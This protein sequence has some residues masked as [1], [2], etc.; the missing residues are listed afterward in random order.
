MIFA[1][2][3]VILFVAVVPSSSSGS[4]CHS[5]CQKTYSVDQCEN[6]C[7]MAINQCSTRRQ[8]PL[9]GARLDKCLRIEI[10]LEP[11]YQQCE[12]QSGQDGCKFMVCQYNDFTH[13]EFSSLGYRKMDS[14]RDT[15][16]QLVDSLKDGVQGKAGAQE[17]VNSL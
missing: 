9:T 15:L 7:G 16:Q 3:A 2:S 12:K 8:N 13:R 6:M 14:L 5:Y 10:D 4:L 11:K 17:C 1:I